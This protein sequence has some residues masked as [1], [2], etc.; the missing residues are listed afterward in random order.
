MLRSRLLSASGQLI[1]PKEITMPAYFE[2]GFSVRQPMW[3]GQG[4][5]LD[6]YPESWDEAR[7]AAG[8]MWE[9]AIR[10]VF[11]RPEP[12]VYVEVPDH[13]LVVRDDS[14]AVIGIVSDG[15]RLV[16]HGAMGE[17]MEAISEQ[18]NVKFETA[19][20]CRGGA[21]V[22][23]L[24][25]VDEPEEIA[26]DDTATLPFIALLN[27]HDG[28]GACKIVNTSV[29]VVCWNTYQAASM[30][31]QRSGR[32]FVFRH[33]ASVH[34]RIEEAKSALAGARGQ[35]TEWR[36][37]AEQ[38]AK[39]PVRAPEFLAF[40]QAFLPDPTEQAGQVISDRVRANIARNR[41]MFTSLY[42]GSP[43][44]DGHRGTALGL[45]DAAVEYLDH[46]RGYRTTDTYLGRTLLRSEP[47]K[48]NAVALAREV[49][50]A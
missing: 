37:M 47:L 41:A 27:S 11:H 36:V 10:P 50:N 45:V 19:G 32:Q 35:Q 31:G 2:S 42:E 30:D 46:L 49:C 43:T 26:G 22:W 3:H 12:E 28:T 29:R 16:S 15:Y 5:V 40:Q 24:A 44:T 25:Y 7:L 1:Q 20:S 18:P 14:E 48:A 9:P 38:L 6:E 4:I 8:L 23:A 33:T 21:Q 39:L 17:I 34:D 13:R